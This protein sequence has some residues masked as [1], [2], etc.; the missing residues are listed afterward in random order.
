[1]EDS[2][3]IL[4]T[5]NNFY[6]Q[7][8]NQLI[9]ITAA[10]LTFAGVVLPILITIYQ[11]RLFKLEHDAIESS[12]TQ[13]MK[14]EL[15]LAIKAI[16]SEYDQKEKAFE[17]QMN[18]LK[19]ELHREIDTAKGGISHV[20]GC[21]S[22]DQSDWINAFES[23][24]GASKSYI[25][26]EDNLNLRRVISMISENCLPNL[27]VDD[28]EQHSDTFENFEKVIETLTTYDNNGIF[29]DQLKSLNRQ[30]IL[31]KKRV[32]KRQDAE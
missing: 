25:K 10:V 13:K 30:F 2:L 24:I 19:E 6:S 9:I 31:C 32:A 21:N 27:N 11:K 12:L 18:D 29:S 16:E 3:K 23:F 1:M 20:Q 17:I 14:D 26:A 28:I 5:V 15:E 7:S 4:E 22:F 8:F